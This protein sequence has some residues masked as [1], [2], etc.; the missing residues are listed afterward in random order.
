MEYRPSTTLHYLLASVALLAAIAIIAVIFLVIPEG[1]DVLLSLLCRILGAVLIAVAIYTVLKARK[2]SPVLTVS[3]QGLSFHDGELTS[4]ANISPPEI[5][6]SGNLKITVTENTVTEE[7]M[8]MK[9]H[10]TQFSSRDLGSEAATVAKD[11]EQRQSSYQEKMHAA[12]AIIAPK[13]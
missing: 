5:T 3:K 10:D 6:P 9:T 12:T 8:T 2:L 1:E 4:W 7:G 13:D 11:I